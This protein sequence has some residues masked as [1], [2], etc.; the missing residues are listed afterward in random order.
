MD[1]RQFF[2]R[3][4][5]ARLAGVRLLEARPGY[6][7]ARMRVSDRTKNG[8]DVAQGGAV[9]TLADLAFAAACNGAGQVAVAAQV[10]ITFHKAG[11]G[12]LTA[13]A[14]EVSRS[15]RLSACEVVVTDRAGDRVATF[16]GLAYVK[17]ENIEDLPA[18]GA[19]R[20]APRRAK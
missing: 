8:L 9:F 7:R 4:R 10:G 20:R 18:P 12:L 16:Q 5:F 1:L 14:R 15:R 13:V 19:R 11:L 2:R 3:D 17:Q 6:A